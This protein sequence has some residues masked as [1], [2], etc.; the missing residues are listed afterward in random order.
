M[1]RQE[2]SE[3]G[4]AFSENGWEGIIVN[5]A[6]QETPFFSIIVPTYN[7]ERELKKC[8]DS[9]LSQSYPDFE[10]IIVNDGSADGTPGI[11]DAYALQ[12]DRVIVIHKRHQ[13]VA[14]ARNEGLFRAAGKYVYYVDADDWI[15]QGLLQEAVSVLGRSQPPDIFIFGYTR[16]LDNGKVIPCSWSLAS[17]LYD[18]K[19]LKEEVYPKLMR[20]IGFNTWVRT[21]SASLC[22]KIIRRDLLVAHYCRDTALFSQEDLVCAYECV[23]FAKQIY[24][25]PLNF[26]VYNQRS[27]SSMHRRYHANLFENNKAAVRYLRCALKSQENTVIER[28]I[29]KLEF[30]GVMGAIYQEIELKRS[31]KVCVHWLKGKLGKEC[32]FLVCPIEGLSFPECVCVLLLSFRL[33]YPAMLIIKLFCKIK[34]ISEK[35]RRTRKISKYKENHEKGRREH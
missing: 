22:D 26:Y 19:R 29:N 12:D 5:N 10:L 16:L 35:M 13:G 11:C 31:L 8:V 14:A 4:M 17:G 24:F 7:N 23:Y 27:E 9:I 25:S 6:D 1:D 3:P 2:T 20:P 28:Q 32:G 15:E 33:V 18:K 30:D 21:V 34:G